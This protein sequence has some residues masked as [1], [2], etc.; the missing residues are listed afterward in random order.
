MSIPSG[1]LSCILVKIIFSKN[2][3]GN[4]QQHGASHVGALTQVT[5]LCQLHP[6][7]CLPTYIDVFL[8]PGL[9]QQRDSITLSLKSKYPN[10]V[11][12]NF[13]KDVVKS[14][15]FV[16]LLTFVLASL[17]SVQR[18][19]LLSHSL[20]TS[21]KCPMSVAHAQGERKG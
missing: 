18:V 8:I 9:N 16:I 13:C 12:P 7:S 2:F 15:C 17:R 4:G 1:I 5:L 19:S 21:S 10:N 20:S 6:K 3:A 14:G 11:F